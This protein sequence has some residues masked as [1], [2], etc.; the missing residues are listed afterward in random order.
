MVATEPELG[1]E[2]NSEADF[3]EDMKRLRYPRFIKNSI[4]LLSCMQLSVRCP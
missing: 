3:S 4:S 2:P 1:S